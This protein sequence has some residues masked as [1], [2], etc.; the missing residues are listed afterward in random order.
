MLCDALYF[1]FFKPGLEFAVVKQR[2]I[3]LHFQKPDLQVAVAIASL[4]YIGA[5]NNKATMQMMLRAES[6]VALEVTQKTSGLCVGEE[7]TSS[8]AR[9]GYHREQRVFFFSS[10]L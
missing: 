2:K 5:R 6:N 10:N 1:I 4:N 7:D 3:I 8:R 9:E